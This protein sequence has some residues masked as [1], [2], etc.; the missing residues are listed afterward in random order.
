MFTFVTRQ[1][2]KGLKAQGNRVIDVSSRAAEPYQLLS[3]F[4]PHGNL[5]VPGMPGETSDS[6]EGIWQGLKVF[7]GGGIDRSYFRGKGRKRRGGKVLGHQCGERL[8]DYFEARRT[9]YI[10][11]YRNMVLTTPAFA[12]ARQLVEEALDGTDTFLHD[13]EAN[14]DPNR[15]KPL[16]HASILC[17]LLQENLE[18]VQRYFTDKNYRVQYLVG[19]LPYRGNLEGMELLVHTVTYPIADAIVRERDADVIARMDTGTM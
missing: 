11:G 16:A 4:Y 19:F 7:E 10:P 14:G 13:F 6:F 5:P 9:I 8:L 2:A 15:R 3:P 18:V 17:A 12:V 1:Q